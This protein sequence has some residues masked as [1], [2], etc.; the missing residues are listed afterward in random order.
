ME[1]ILYADNDQD[2]LAM[3]SVN[4]QFVAARV[5]TRLVSGDTV[6]R[7]LPEEVDLISGGATRP[8]GLDIKRADTNQ[9][10]QS[11][12]LDTDGKITEVAPEATS[13]S[14]QVS[15]TTVPLAP[16]VNIVRTEQAAVVQPHFKP[17]GA[18]RGHK[19]SAKFA[20]IKPP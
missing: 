16:S 9:R 19:A 11:A 4:G 5:G 8:L 1:G 15:A 2:S 6:S 20:N 7:I 14:P 17:L 3:L 18:L 10:I 13:S 12:S